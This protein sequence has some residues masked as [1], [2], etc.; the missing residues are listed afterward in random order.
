MMVEVGDQDNYCWFVAN[1]IIFF[2]SSVTPPVPSVA[3][4]STIAVL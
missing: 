1:E 2:Y 4:S 3:T